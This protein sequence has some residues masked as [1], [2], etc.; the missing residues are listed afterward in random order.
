M[1]GKEEGSG[2]DDVGL[3]S[4]LGQ[5]HI[6]DA[7]EVEE[8]GPVDQDVDAAEAAGCG[9]DGGQSLL[10]VGDVAGDSDGVAARG[11]DGGGAFPGVFPRGTSTQTRRAP[12]RASSSAIP[13]MM[14]GLVPVTSAVLPSSF[15]RFPL[16]FGMGGA[17]AQPSPGGRGVRR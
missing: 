3:P 1:L 11:D 8:R 5:G 9:G 2:E 7:L 14:L 17:L 6:E 15:K 4:P 13:P 16:P 12:S 10:L